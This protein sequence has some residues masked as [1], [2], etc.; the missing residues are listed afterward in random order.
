MTLGQQAQLQYA[1]N[2]LQSSQQQKY[3]QAQRQFTEARLRADSGAAVPDGEYQQD[4]QTYFAQPGDTPE[5]LEQKRIARQQ[6]LDAM[7]VQSG[8]AYR[9]FYGQ[10]PIQQQKGQQSSAPAANRPQQMMLN[11]KVLTLQ[12]DGTYQ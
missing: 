7:A 4:A 5:V 11:G 6:V 8:P 12:A 1:P 9:D 3:R 10:M 2:I